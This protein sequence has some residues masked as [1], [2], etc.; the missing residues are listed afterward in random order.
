MRVKLSYTVESDDV[1]KEAAKILNLRAEDLQHAI[2]L[3]GLVQKELAGDSE[4]NLVPNTGRALEMLT[5]FRQVLLAIDLR[6]E[7]VAEMVEGY[8]D[9]QRSLRTPTPALVP[10]ETSPL[11]RSTAQ[12]EQPAPAPQRPERALA[13]PP[14]PRR[15]VKSSVK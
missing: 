9:Y 6:L 8:S 13:H 2:N 10:P 15:K 3:F 7:E 4:E 1:L 14:A 11:P 12:P 5:E